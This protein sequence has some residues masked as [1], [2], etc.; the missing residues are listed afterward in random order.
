MEHIF[1]KKILYKDV[2]I[3][4]PVASSSDARMSTSGG[5]ESWND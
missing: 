1:F 4:R 5:E 3:K 2:V